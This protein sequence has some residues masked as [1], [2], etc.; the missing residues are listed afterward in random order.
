[1]NKKPHS[2]PLD[3]IRALFP[4]ENY[5]WGPVFKRELRLDEAYGLKVRMP[6]EVFGRYDCAI[7][8]A[9]LQQFLKAQG[10][11][12]AK[13]MQGHDQECLFGHHYWVDLKGMAVDVT[14]L[15]P[16]VGANH[17]AEMD[18]PAPIPLSFSQEGSAQYVAVLGSVTPQL[19]WHQ[20]ATQTKN[21]G[22]SEVE[23]RYEL[24]QCEKGKPQ[25]K[26]VL[27]IIIDVEKARKTSFLPCTTEGITALEKL[28]GVSIIQTS[29]YTRSITGE[30]T[31]YWSHELRAQQDWDVVGIFTLNVVQLLKQKYKKKARESSRFKL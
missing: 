31:N 27:S 1:M 17:V 24:C 13:V 18:I 8:S 23:I 2:L 7:G 15:F 14:P 9:R 12:E 29:E 26:Y 5:G 20:F 10:F 21:S 30:N 22:F 16:L 6:E 4:P 11:L 25:Q 28:A 3:F 19:A